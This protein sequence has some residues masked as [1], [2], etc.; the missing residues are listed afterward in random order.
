MRRV[1]PF[2][3]FIAL[4]IQ[5][6][7]ACAP[8]YYDESSAGEPSGDAS[9]ANESSQDDS[10][11]D[12]MTFPDRCREILLDAYGGKRMNSLRRN[13][14]IIPTIAAASVLLN[15]QQAFI[16]QKAGL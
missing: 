15:R 4:A 1:L 16:L 10:V 3:I 6:L 8:V 11:F 7:A 13:S 9:I 12:D 2:L 14:N 5:L